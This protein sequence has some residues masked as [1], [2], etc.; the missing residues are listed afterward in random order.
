MRTSILLDDRLGEQLKEKARERG[1][2]LSAFLAEAGRAALRSDSRVAQKPFEL[3]TFEGSGVQ[4][5]IDLDRTSELM[6]AEDQT[7]YGK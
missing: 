2:S 3:I 1:M 5:G 7:R 6:A 4:A